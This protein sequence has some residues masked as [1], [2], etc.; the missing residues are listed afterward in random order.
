MGK[1]FLSNHL[2]LSTY[3]KFVLLL[4]AYLILVQPSISQNSNI[5]S[6]SES[7]SFKRDF[8]YLKNSLLGSYPSLY[9]YTSKSK[10]DQ[11]FDSSYASI[12][13]NTTTLQFYKMIKF[14]ISAI[15]D[16][17]LYVSAPPDVKIFYTESAK[18]CPLKLQFI[19]NKAFVMWSPVNTMFPG[20]E[21][22]SINGISINDI[23]K[24]LFCYS[25]SDGFNETRKYYVINRNFR[26]YYYMVFGEQKAFDVEYKT[27]MGLIKKITLNAMRGIQIPADTDM[28]TPKKLL[29]LKYIDNTALLTI[30]TFDSAELSK[31]DENFTA[32]LKC[33][34]DDIRKRKINALI[35]DL[36]GNGGGMD[37]YAS[38]LYSYLATKKFS[39]INRL[40][41]STK[42]L[43]Y[44]DFKKSV[45]SFNNLETSM[46][47]SSGLNSY[48]LK[49]ISH[50]GLIPINPMPNNYHGKV[51]FL[52]NGLSFSATAEF[53]T[54]A[55]TNDRGKFIGEETGG[56]YGGNTSGAMINCTLPHSKITVSY[57]LVK[58]ELAIGD[59]KNGSRGV[60][61]DYSLLPTIQDILAKKDVQLDY[62]LKLAK[63]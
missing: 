29:N 30:N 25:V 49:S 42:D 5:H 4:F 53:C 19:E 40:T 20:T 23:K 17:H 36:R 52:I 58:Y 44:K 47:D 57:G 43:P 6:I 51:W 16:G 33:S 63:N 60:V 38:L 55:R 34:F 12:N 41:V 61:P 13:E 59:E 22:T 39:F 3:L 48:T 8:I 27:E 24:E 1:D 50:D 18:F 7:D 9:R 46:L 54:L 35:I 2:S 26:F 28:A 56:A 15:R 11:L 62:A 37:S 10:M 21:I 32:F 45:S 14:I 31:S